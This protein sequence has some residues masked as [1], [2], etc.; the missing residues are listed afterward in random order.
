MTKQEALLLFASHVD[1]PGLKSDFPDIDY[2]IT[3]LEDGQQEITI[4]LQGIDK[5]FN[6]GDEISSIMAMTKEDIPD[7]QI[8]NIIVLKKLQKKLVRQ[9]EHRR[10]LALLKRIKA[11]IIPAGVPISKIIKVLQHNQ[12]VEDE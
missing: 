8:R 2:I 6:P 4:R 5:D 7:G 9:R 1:I 10:N 12:H 3:E 11:L